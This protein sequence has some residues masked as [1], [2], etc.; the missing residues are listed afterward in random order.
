MTKKTTFIAVLLVFFTPVLLAVLLNSQWLDWRPGETRNHGELITPPPRLDG[1]ELQTAA[2]IR[3]S[4]ED[5]AG[6][7]QLLHYRSGECGEGCLDALYWMRQVRT[8]QDRH[9][10]EVGLMLISESRLDAATLAA[11]DELARDIRVVHA[12]AGL[13]LAESLP[14]RGSEAISYIVDP[15][16][17]IILRYPPEAEFNGMRRDLKRLLTWTQTGPQ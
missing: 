8:A 4:R 14:D 13:A 16:G 11:I 3:L 7:W 6:Q 17:H 1:F 15:D 12:E 10:P 2:G 5:L 9:Q